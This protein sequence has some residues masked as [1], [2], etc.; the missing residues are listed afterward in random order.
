M[1][2]RTKLLTAFLSILIVMLVTGSIS[3]IELQKLHQSS[4]EIAIQDAPLANAVMEMQLTAT[5]AHLWLEELMAGKEA[6]NK[7]TSIQQLLD[8]SLWYANAITNGGTNEKGT[9][10]PV[11]D[12]AIQAQIHAVKYFLEKLVNL[13]QLRFKNQFESP[14][15]NDQELDHDFDK[16]FEQFIINTQQAEV[17]LRTKLANDTTRLDEYIYTIKV[18]LISANLLAIMIA[19]LAGYYIVREIMYQVGGEPADIAYLTKQIASGNLDLSFAKSTTMVTGIYAAIQQMVKHLQTIS[20]AQ[21]Q[22][23]WLK[24]GQTQLSEQLSGEQNIPQLATQ[25]INF[26]TPYLEAQVGAFYLLKES[27]GQ[28][29]YLK[30]TASYAY[31]WRN[32]SNYEFQIGEGIVGQAALERK[33]FVTQKAPSNYVSIQ[34]GLGETKPCAILV[35]PIL[36]ENNLKGAIEL[37]AFNPFT[38]IHLEFLQQVLPMIAIAINTAQS[39]TQMQKLLEQSQIQAE[40]LQVQQEE[41]QQTN[42]ELLIQKEELQQTNE[43]LHEQTEELQ[44]QQEQLGHTNK[45]LEERSQELE[46]QQA[47]IYEKN[48]E[49]EQIKLVLEANLDDLELTSKYKSEFL[50][51]ISHELRTPLNSL[52]ILAQLLV[53]NKE[54]NLTT[55]QLKYAQT[56]YN[57]GEDLLNLINDIL[58][59]SKVEAGKMAIN[60]EQVAIAEVIVTLENRFRPV[61]QEKG[62]NLV[63]Q[64]TDDLPLFLYTDEQ[65]LIQILTNLIGNACKFTHQGQITVSIHRPSNQTDLSLSQ[66]NPATSLAIDISDTG[67][68][69]PQDKQKDIFDAFQQVD[70]TTSRQYGGTG[71]GLSISRQLTQ[72]LGGEIQLHSKEGKGSVFTVYLPEQ[73]TSP[74][75]ATELVQLVVDVPSSPPPTPAL[76]SSPPLQQL[77]VNTSIQSAGELYAPPS[78]PPAPVSALSPPVPQ[79]TVNTST[80]STWEDDRNNLQTGDRFV[81][82]IE[83]ELRFAQILRKIAHNNAFKCLLAQDGHSGLQLVEQ[84]QPHAILLDIGLPKIDGWTVMENLK[85]NP[86][87]RHIPVYF[88][89]GSDYRQEAKQLG[90]IGYCLKPINGEKLANTFNTIDYFITK[91]VKDLLIIFDN[92]SQQPALTEIVQSEH[93]QVT[94]A[95]TFHDAY[96]QLQSNQFDCVI[97]DISA[98]QHTG[99][100]LLKQV[101]IEPKLQQIPVIIYAERELT[102]PEAAIVEKYTHELVIKEVHSPEQLLD[103]VT[104]FLHQIDSQLSPFQQQL[105]HK[106]RTQQGKL[107]GKKVL[108]VDDDMR[109]V[110]TLGATLEEKGMDVLV[111]N[112]G[113]KALQCLAEQSNIAIILMDIMMPG[114][115]GYETIRQIRTQ[116]QFLKLPIIALT[117]KAMKGEKNK[118]LEA[119]ASDYLAKPVDTHQLFSLLRVWI[120]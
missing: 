1:K 31:T 120:Y 25:V 91:V 36:Y 92:Q 102:S 4:M 80:Q 105:L 35:I 13:T 37:A 94:S 116:P 100:Q 70:G 72:L 57:S 42:E 85:E 84:Y 14:T 47:A 87:T 19:M 22:Q 68:G 28:P 98:E 119:G 117:A 86:N 67:I 55:E 78:P 77:T 99:L 45:Q 61:A 30:M 3:L 71:L 50:A 12:L 112:D 29:P 20:Q 16:I 7:I 6:S 27:E 75:A 69:I 15:N 103:E 52:L 26:L 114:I 74:E 107:T 60:L 40:E 23:N 56:I 54:G 2:I 62:L 111:A 9:F 90:A 41:L 51:N 10:Y 96:Q 97:L 88:I 79:L 95:T 38:A 24:S 109:N 64:T 5:S 104:L 83:D 58:D 17:A 106:V 39:R 18:I 43:Q 101:F 113:H 82:I 48:I 66:L 118:C 33:L 89:S 93:I 115:D 73:L 46:R 44:T 76:A 59:L 63:I 81:V 32:N 49:L 8:Q 65:R 21:T 34:S 110:F 53:D 11:K 108:L